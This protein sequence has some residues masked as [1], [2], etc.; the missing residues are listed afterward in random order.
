MTLA[1]AL[2]ALV[3]SLIP[4]LLFLG[5]LPLFCWLP[6]ESPAGNGSLPEVSG[7]IPFPAGPRHLYQVS[8]RHEDSRATE[9]KKA[10]VRFIAT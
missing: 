3:L 4:A 6:S 2:A 1:L 5:H 10:R 8:A 7:L 9:M